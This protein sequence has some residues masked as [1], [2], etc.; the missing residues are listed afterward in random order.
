VHPCNMPDAEIE[1]P[2]LV[3]GVIG[4]D[5]ASAQSALSG[6]GFNVVQGPTVTVENE[7]QNGTVVSQSPEGG[8]YL[9]A[10]ETVTV[11]L[12]VYVAP[13]PGPDPVP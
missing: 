4:Q 6:A 10:G 5:F 11:N 9:D 13:D 1:C 7:A 8:A 12:G 3:P 2:I